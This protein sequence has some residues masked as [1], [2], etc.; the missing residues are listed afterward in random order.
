MI[1]R[2]RLFLHQTSPMNDPEPDSIPVLMPVRKPRW[3]GLVLYLAVG[4]G[5]FFATS[6]AIGVLMQLGV[7][8]GIF[9][10]A[11]AALSANVV[12]FLGTA[13]LFGITRGQFPMRPVRMTWVW[14]A[15]AVALALILLPV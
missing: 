2:L 1:H 3:S 6:V 12:C 9:Q 8:N 5:S 7:L 15:I 11:V 4:V 14:A 13:W 10:V